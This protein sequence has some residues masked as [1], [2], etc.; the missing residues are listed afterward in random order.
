MKYTK[1]LMETVVYDVED[2]LTAS[3]TGDNPKVSLVEAE[4]TALTGIG[5]TNNGDQSTIQS[6]FGIG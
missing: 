4:N 2:I 1:P 5:G 3:G 6:L